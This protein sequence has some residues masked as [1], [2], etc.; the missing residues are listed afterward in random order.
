MPIIQLTPKLQHAV[1]MLK[2]NE[3]REDASPFLTELSLSKVESA[4]AVRTFNRPAI[5]RQK[6]LVKLAGDWW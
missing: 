5:A 4:A 2:R 6:D 1:H 3:L